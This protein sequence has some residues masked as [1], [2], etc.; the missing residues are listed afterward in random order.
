M[1]G[2]GKMMGNENNPEEEGFNPMDMCRRMMSSMNEGRNLAS[3]AT[4]EIRGLFED[5][6]EQ[7]HEEILGYMQK[8]QSVNV[9]QIA[10]HLKLSAESVIYL[11]GTLAKEGK[12]K[13]AAEVASQ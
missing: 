8:Q 9:E 10:D 5:W 1:E 3:F 12:V 6:V 4:P 2:M 13:L 7:I 11:L